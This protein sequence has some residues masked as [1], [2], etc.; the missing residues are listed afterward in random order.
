MRL[1]K[2]TNRRLTALL[3]AI[4]MIGALALVRTAVQIVRSNE[5]SSLIGVVDTGAY[6]IDSESTAKL[7]P[8]VVVESKSGEAEIIGKPTEV[9]LYAASGKCINANHWGFAA[10]HAQI[11]LRGLLLVAMIVMLLWFG[12]NTLLDAKSGR[13]FTLGNLRILYT[14]APTAFLY[15]LITENIYIW[16]Q[17]AICELY[18]DAALIP[19]CGQFTITAGTIII[20][21]LTITVAELYKA[22]IDLN[23]EEQMTV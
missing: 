9:A 17:I 20:P 2:Q 15:M 1:T 16:Q 6:N 14:L 23:D 22:A 13:L 12:T 3:V 5:E 18:A 7:P 21:L 11:Y 10:W 4:S 19:L 8:I